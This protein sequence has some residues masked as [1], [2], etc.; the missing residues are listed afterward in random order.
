V[1]GGRVPAAVRPVAASL[2]Q[3]GGQAA[4]PG[5]GPLQNLLYQAGYPALLTR[6]NLLFRKISLQSNAND[7]NQEPSSRFPSEYRIYS[8]RKLSLGKRTDERQTEN[9]LLFSIN[10]M[11]RRPSLE[12]ILKLS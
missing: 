11:F 3:A 12:P 10:A 9:L 4:G 5:R 7:E 8:H 6:F 2:P 1:A